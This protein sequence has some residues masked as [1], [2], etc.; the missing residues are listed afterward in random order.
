MPND[1]KTVKSAT[2]LRCMP[3]K[4]PAEGPFG[5]NKAKKW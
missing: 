1:H 4:V 3:E 5:Y 2:Y